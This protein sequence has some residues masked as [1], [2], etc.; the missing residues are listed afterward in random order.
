MIAFLVLYS[1]F[2]HFS[3]LLSS[4]QPLRQIYLVRILQST[5]D[6]FYA[7]LP[8]C[9]AFLLRGHRLLI[10]MFIVHYSRTKR[11]GLFASWT[12][13]V[14]LWLEWM[15]ST[16][17]YSQTIISLCFIFFSTDFF[18]Q[19]SFSC[20]PSCEVVELLPRCPSDVTDSGGEHELSNYL[21]I[22]YVWFF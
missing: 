18:N 3:L 10:F 12:G 21:L 4:G 7:W 14:C 9:F 16:P 6:D 11:H 20:S 5:L 17:L 1:V 2:N 22:L 15:W 19:I 13:I 8:F